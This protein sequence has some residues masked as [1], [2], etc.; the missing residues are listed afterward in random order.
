M[1]NTAIFV[2]ALIMLFIFSPLQYNNNK[3]TK[4]S[5]AQTVSAVENLMP[6]DDMLPKTINKEHYAESANTKDIITAETHNPR[7]RSFVSPAVDGWTNYGYNWLK[8]DTANKITVQNG[9][10]VLTTAE[11]NAMLGIYKALANWAKQTYN[12]TSDYTVNDS[13]TPSDPS[14]DYAENGRVAFDTAIQTQFPM[15][16]QK[17][18]IKPSSSPET[19]RSLRMLF[20][21]YSI[22]QSDNPQ[23]YQLLADNPRFFENGTSIVSILPMIAPDCASYT[24]RQNIQSRINAEYQQYKDFIL[25]QNATNHYDIVRLIHDMI[26]AKSDYYNVINS[27]GKY[28]PD[29]APTA[30]D[31]RGVLLFDTANGIGPV[32]ESFAETFT[33]IIRR[34]RNDLSSA[35]PGIANLDAITVCGT[36]GSGGNG[37]G[38]GHA[39]NIVKLDG[40]WYNL[41]ITWDNLDNTNPNSS[42]YDSG[43]KLN[44]LYYKFF[45]CG[46]NNTDFTPSHD[47]AS[48][49]PTNISG[50][51][52][53]FI[54]ELPTRST[55][56]YARTPISRTAPL[57]SGT[58]RYLTDNGFYGK[59]SSFSSFNS[60]AAYD[61]FDYYIWKSVNEIDTDL[62]KNPLIH[63]TSKYKLNYGP[64]NLGTIAVNDANPTLPLYMK[65]YDSSS[66]LP[67]CLMDIYD[68]D[69]T[70]SRAR[71]NLTQ[72]KDYTV[73]VENS[74]ANAGDTVRVWFYGKGGY[75]GVDFALV[76]L[77]A[78]VSP[79][80]PPITPPSPPITPPAPPIAPP[81]PPP[82]DTTAPVLS[83]GTVKRINS[84]NA[85]I[86]FTT[87]ET[88]TAYYKVL[89]SGTASPTEAEVKNR[90][91]LGIVSGTVSDKSITITADASDIYV[92][93]A[94][95]AGN[96]SKPLKISVTAYIE[97]ISIKGISGV[98]P[99]IAG[100]KATTAISETAQ[101][102]G[103]VSWS[104]SATTFDY[105]T[106]YTAT[107]T[108]T[109]KKGYTLTGVSAN[110][111]TVA[112]AIT[113][114]NTENSGVITAAFPKTA[115]NQQIQDDEDI[116][117]AKTV[118]EKHNWIATQAECYDEA[119]VTAKIKS[120]IENLSLHN[121][122]N[123]TLEKIDCNE[124]VAGTE[125]NTAGIDGFCTFTANL[126]K[127]QAVGKTTNISMKVTATK[128][129]AA[130]PSTDTDTT[131]P[132]GENND[133][134]SLDSDNNFAPFTK[135]QVI[136]GGGI[137][138]FLLLL[139]LL[140]CRKRKNKEQR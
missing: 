27:Q 42:Q 85:T 56:D 79:P 29:D 88:G 36:A 100:E 126:T 105:D 108:L 123:F 44:L 57:P 116:K 66:G 97:T 1:K 54:H 89:P 101:Y 113:V 110:F 4:Q 121:K 14:D 111:F 86:N 125:N 137:F 31:I 21:T 5:Y 75:K 70:A 3:Q 65:P 77:T 102:T 84:T 60:K 114:S 83:G 71:I 35:V 67:S 112:K 41:D 118:L 98:T 117:H 80:S 52:A 20:L 11:V 10:P 18:I 9:T 95:S 93:V 90:I 99:P 104:P 130:P 49:H 129:V 132:T 62:A 87:D 96:I 139:L 92:V 15:E 40:N 61:D 138:L 25:N 30:H 78:A 81:S 2:L 22:F 136:I 68:L 134:A 128:Y 34:L 37:G 28:V 6:A 69:P 39:W 32:C 140:L 107:I 119:S 73:K 47:E 127:G 133:N 115:L 124:P 26:C 53:F 91:S 109:P 59:N 17:Y 135:E 43:N 46:T 33:Y 8:N 50:K 120:V 76:T 12:S 51:G 103:T 55:T 106:D 63:E 45:L 13:G 72:G 82:A 58:Y 64:F 19:E 131:P 74:N 94:D 48:S 24:A 122:V 38:G 23:Y 7:Q 16:W